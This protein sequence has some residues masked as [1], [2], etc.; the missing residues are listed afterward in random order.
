MTHDQKLEA[1]AAALCEAQRSLTPIEPLSGD[2]EAGDIDAAYA[3][4]SLVTERGL[5]ERRRLVGR[6][7]G[8]TAAAV[9]RQMGIDQP[10]FGVLFADM[11]V[12][13]GETAPADRLIQPKVEGEIAFVLGSDLREAQPTPADVIAAVD[14]AVAAI[15]IVDSRISD[16]R[17]DIFDTI[18][19]NASS[20]LFVLG[21]EPRPLGAL[22]LRHCGM[23]LDVD[24]VPASVGAG[25][26]CLGHPLNAA[27]WLARKMVAVGRPLA[28]GDVILSGALGPMTPA[29]PGSH[30]R[31]AISGLGGVSVRFADREVAQ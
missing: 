15:E 7:I 27:L 4:Q 1:A 24:G 21:S 11:A 14:Y 30:V 29:P 19:D 13:E 12:P 2:F 28:A 17:I 31:L 6:K 9:Q 23:V 22:D 8:L 20:G 3:V 26:A 25:A 10:D 5:A 18:A 16:W